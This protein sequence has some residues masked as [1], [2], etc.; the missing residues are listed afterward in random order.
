MPSGAE[1]SLSNLM[2][3]KPSSDAAGS[4]RGTI[5]QMRRCNMASER[6][7]YGRNR[8]RWLAIYLVVGA[9]AYFV[10]YLAFFHHGD[11]GGGFHY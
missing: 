9:V 11:G 3:R 4:T 7:G 8:K 2:T 5:E 1:S 6:S 10:V